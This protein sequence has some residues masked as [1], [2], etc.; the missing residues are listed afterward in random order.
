MVAKTG[1]GA[2]V[3]DDANANGSRD[4][5]SGNEAGVAGV[6]VTLYAPDGVT[7]LAQTTTDEHGYYTFQNLA[8]ATYVVGF[9]HLPASTIFTQQGAGSAP[10]TATGK[11]AAI[12]LTVGSFYSDANA[13][14]ILT[15]S[16]GDRVWI[17][18]NQNGLQDFDEVSMTDPVTVKL[19]RMMSA[20]AGGFP[21]PTLIATTT[22]DSKG[23]YFF[24]GLA[25]GGYVVEFGTASGYTRTMQVTNTDNGSLPEYYSGKTP[26]F[27]LAAGRSRTDIDA[28]YY[29]GVQL[30]VTLLYF[31]AEANPNNACQALLSWSTA[32]EQN[33]AYFIVERST[34]GVR[35]MPIDTIGGHGNTTT[36][37]YYN[38][39][40]KLAHHKGYYR[41]RQV[42]Y[43]GH[44]DVFTA[45]RP[46]T[47]SECLE[48]SNMPD[49]V[50]QL[51][52]NP[53]SATGG[54]KAYLKCVGIG[55]QFGAAA[56]QV[57]DITGRQ[58]RDMEVI[59]ERG[60]NVLTID[61]ANLPAGN[62]IVR[63]QCPADEKERTTITRTLI[64]IP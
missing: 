28:G 43:D 1:I 15:A 24:E 42:D 48:V 64:V 27:S 4:T 38:Y 2:Y 41:L 56:L 30:P 8:P 23:G 59:L 53:S 57:Y 50:S 26:L 35:F 22:T 31:R 44:S 62:Y 12:A 54:G 46:V 51:Y 29:A 45:I 14:L 52:P 17:D 47:L 11:T 32:S 5:L 63:L 49:G 36:T 10:N 9:S 58:I 7:A 25:G 16:I 33:N 3:Y 18:D 40:D 61:I 34:D 37:H 39:T 19:Y 20:G 21:T 6:T 55:G 60:E 13:G